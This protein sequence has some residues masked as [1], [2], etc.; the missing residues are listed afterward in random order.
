MWGFGRRMAALRYLLAVGVLAGIVVVAVLLV[1]NDG[2]NDGL[3]SAV[4]RQSPV[5]VKSSC[6]RPNSRRKRRSHGG[7]SAPGCWPRRRQ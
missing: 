3:F 5:W 2:L 7:G 6:P 1:V 4:R